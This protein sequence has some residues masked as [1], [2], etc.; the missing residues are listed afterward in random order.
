MKKQT[1]N[2]KNF[3]LFLFLLLFISIIAVKG[4]DSTS[5]MDKAPEKIE[6]IKAPFNMPQL[7][8]PVFP[9]HTFNI[10]DYGAVEGGIVKCTEAI[11]KAIE[12]AEKVGGGK[13]VIPAGKWLTGAIHLDNNINLYVS[14]GAEVLFSQDEKDYL[15]VVFS[16]HEDIEC[17]KFSAFIYA[18]GKKNIAITGEGVLFGQGKPWLNHKE[19]ELNADKELREMAKNNVPVKDRIFDGT[20]N[21]MLRPAF[22]Q[23]MNCTNVL[24]EGVTF[25]Y[26]AFWTITPTYCTNVI[27]RK[28]K[29][30]TEGKYGHIK[31][32][33]GVDPSSCKNVLIEYCDIST[34]DDCIAIKSGRDEDGLR[35][36][37]PTENVVVRHCDFRSGHGGITIGSETSGGIN[38]IYGY[39]C[40]SDGTDRALR[41]KTGRGRGAVVQNLWFKDI[42]AK[43]IVYEAIDINMLY[44]TKRLPEEP[45]SVT[46]PK[47]KNFHF[48]NIS[49]GY[50]NTYGIEILGLPEMPIENLTFKHINIKSKKGI[51]INDAKNIKF[52]DV[53]VIPETYPLV[54]LLNAKDITFNKLYIS[55]GSDPAFKIED[56]ATKN[57]KIIN[58]DLSIAKEK[59]VFGDGVKPGALKISKK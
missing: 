9:N 27:V 34:G 8:R 59:V 30:V 26:G 55:A 12:A 32:G 3:L 19:A 33:D 11:R 58:T 49:C 4:Q 40:I 51:I 15:P 16:R 29:I 14:K 52:F 44:T 36:H 6:P 17:Y 2:I 57:I 56:N 41:I 31:N 39:D 7:K 25:K 1:L 45:V 54:D 20:H 5:V 48:E 23:P 13:V 43:R 47:F 38:N 24:V 42:S 28:V 37:K 50:A 35:V 21:D 46:T 53:S 22:F 10:K 18:N